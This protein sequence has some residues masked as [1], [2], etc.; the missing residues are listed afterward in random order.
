MG[1]ASQDTPQNNVQ[2]TQQ[3]DEGSG[4]TQTQTPVSNSNTQATT[5]H[6]QVD[7]VL[8]QLNERVEHTARNLLQTQGKSRTE[9]E[10]A[11][12]QHFQA[13]EARA[14]YQRTLA[15]VY[16]N[17]SSNKED[18][19]V[20][21]NM[22]MLQIKGG[23]MRDANKVVHESVQAFFTSFEAQ[24]RSRP[25]NL[26]R[27]WERL[28]WTTL[29]SQQ[30]QWAAKRLAGNHFTWDQAKKEIQKMYGNPLYT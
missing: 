12:H 14:I 30:H 13:Q 23:P 4:A 25:L 10:E 26:N 21:S 8:V 20:P 22:P 6:P 1:E 19:I 9:H 18:Q 29:D 16:A 27:H 28:I 11:M 3:A 17:T 2:E 7:S 15:N 24:L 5:R